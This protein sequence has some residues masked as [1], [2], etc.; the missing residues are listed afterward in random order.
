MDKTI[1]LIDGFNFYHSVR[2]LK[3]DTGHSTKWFDIAA[4]CKSY[5]Y[6]FGKEARLETIYYFSAIPYYLTHSKPDTIKRQKD[7]ILC[8]KSTGIKVELGRFKKKYVYCD[9]CRKDILKHEEKETDVAIAVK[10]LEIC[11]TDAADNVIIVSGDS[12]LSPAVRTCLKFFPKTKIVCAFPY[13]RQSEELKVL[14]PKSFNISKEK[15]VQHQL[16]NPVVLDYGRKVF[17]PPT[18]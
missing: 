3:E 6:L 2:D 12:D 11:F 5:L 17:K 18:W 10:L 14:V 9:R 7:Y 4:L 13:N 15:Y 8:L 1:F 16:P